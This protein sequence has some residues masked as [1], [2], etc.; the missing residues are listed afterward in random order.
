MKGRIGTRGKHDG[1]EKIKEACGL[2]RMNACYDLGQ[3]YLKGRFVKRNIKRASEFFR[4]GCQAN[5]I[6]SCKALD[7]KWWQ[8]W[9]WG[10]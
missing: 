7:V 9:K 8:V 10:L 6:K 4:Q 5:H 2:G 1:L 3:F